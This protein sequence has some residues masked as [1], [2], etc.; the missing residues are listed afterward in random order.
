MTKVPVYEDGEVIARVEYNSNLDFWDG[1]NMTS[2]SLGRHLGFT[3]LK[4]S[5]KYVLINGTNW[6]GEQP[7]AEVVTMDE[8]IKAATRT[9]HL[10]DVYAAYP[11][12]KGTLDEEEVAVA[13]REEIEAEVVAFGNGAHITLPKDLIGRRVRYTVIEG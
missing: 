6:E 3:K 10:D 7:S 12:L 13:P 11:E 5:G 4:K 9:G 2:G 8:L 1:R